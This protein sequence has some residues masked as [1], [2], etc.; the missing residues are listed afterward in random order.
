MRIWIR[1]PRNGVSNIKSAV[2]LRVW[3]KFHENG[4]EIPYPQRDL[5]LIAPAEVTLAQTMRGTSAEE[6]VASV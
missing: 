6:K 1:D 2:L 4:I 3:D 5:H